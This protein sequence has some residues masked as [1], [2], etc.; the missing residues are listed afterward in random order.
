[1][2]TST[3]L[4]AKTH[5]IFALIMYYRTIKYNNP[6][7]LMLFRNSVGQNCAKTFQL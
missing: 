5:N 3:N 1:M 2:G 4:D 7:H 6:S